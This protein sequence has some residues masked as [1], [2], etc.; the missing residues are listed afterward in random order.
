MERTELLIYLLIIAAIV[1]LIV[2]YSK[3]GRKD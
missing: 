1:Y 3:S 2:R